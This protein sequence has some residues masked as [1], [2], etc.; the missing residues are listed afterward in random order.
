MSKYKVIQDINTLS[1]Q[2]TPE[3][4]SSMVE[5]ARRIVTVHRLWSSLPAL[6]YLPFR[7]ILSGI[8]PGL[9]HHNEPECKSN[10]FEYHFDASGALIQ[11]ASYGKK[12]QVE[13][14]EW[15][16]PASN[17][18]IEQDK[19][20]D[21]LAATQLTKDTE[22]NIVSAIHLSDD[23]QQ[24]FRYGYTGQ[25]VSSILTH[26]RINDYRPHEIMVTTD[27][28]HQ[29]DVLSMRVTQ[30]VKNQSE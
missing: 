29:R 13:W 17:M 1:A 5:H 7:L 14:R 3:T 18:S 24:H 26:S 27:V 10:A 2:L 23:T 11:I 15:I 12:G 20:G 6:E 19:Y 4:I 28:R 21:F 9:L 8:Q 16:D 25:S 22:G 30:A